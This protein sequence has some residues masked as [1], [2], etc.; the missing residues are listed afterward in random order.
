MGLGN[1]RARW[2]KPIRTVNL[3]DT[4]QH[5]DFLK[6]A[7][8]VD[9]FVEAFRPGVV[10]RLGVDYAAIK[11]VN[12]AIIYCSI[13]AFGQSGQY[14][15][16]PAHDLIVQAMAGTADLTRSMDGE[17]TLTPMPA[18]DMTASLHALSAILMARAI[19]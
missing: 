19:I 18:A 14:R 8:E 1:L 12:P 10:E 6:L 7:E 5:A 13:S 2:A 3:K 11:A 17:P 16:K 4:E 9:V 15:D